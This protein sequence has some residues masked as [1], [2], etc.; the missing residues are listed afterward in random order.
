MPNFFTIDNGSVEEV[1]T[2]EVRTG[3][4][5]DGTSVMYVHPGNTKM[6]MRRA[7][8]GFGGANSREVC[9]LCASHNGTYVYLHDDGEKVTVVVTDKDMNP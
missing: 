1:E 3:T 5:E 6:H 9:W 8:K 4:S 2:E 7:I